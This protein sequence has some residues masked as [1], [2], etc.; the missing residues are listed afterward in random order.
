ME[1]QVKNPLALW[2]EIRELIDVHYRITEDLSFMGRYPEIY[3]LYLTLSA[4]PAEVLQDSENE[5]PK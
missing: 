3:H 2:Y 4:Q 5:Q 1:I